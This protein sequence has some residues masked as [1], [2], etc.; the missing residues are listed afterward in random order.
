MNYPG[1]ELRGIRFFY[2]KSVDREEIYYPG[3]GLIA[4]SRALG[5]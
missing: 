4:R 1:A 2:E 3:V 5:Y